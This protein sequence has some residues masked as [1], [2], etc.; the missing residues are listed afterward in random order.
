MLTR[1]P[2]SLPLPPIEL[3]RP[4]AIRPAPLAA[5]PAPAADD[6]QP[7][8]FRCLGRRVTRHHVECLALCGIWVAL[9]HLRAAEMLPPAWMW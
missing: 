7:P 2:R 8:S 5:A 1:D 6:P 9:V 3:E 4:L